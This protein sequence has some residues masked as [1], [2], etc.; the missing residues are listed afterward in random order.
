MEGDEAGGRMSSHHSKL[1]IE[2]N[3]I[4]VVSPLLPGMTR[5]TVKI[6]ALVSGEVCSAGE[7]GGD[8]T[9]RRRR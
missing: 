9:I 2:L 7:D 3:V 6:N 8:E 4:K 5:S 1:L